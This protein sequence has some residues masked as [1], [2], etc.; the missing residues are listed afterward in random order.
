MTLPS[1]SEEEDEDEDEEADDNERTLLS[2]LTTTTPAGGCS[3]PPLPQ[4]RANLLA[5]VG[6]ANT[7]AGIGNNHMSENTTK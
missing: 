4:R 7:I 6:R 5:S 1:I 2:P 3:S